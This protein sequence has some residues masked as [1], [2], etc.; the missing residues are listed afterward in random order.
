MEGST[1]VDEARPDLVFFVVHPWLSTDRWKPG[2]SHLIERADLVLVNRPEGEA[3]PPWARV[4]RRIERSRR[5]PVVVADAR[6]P[7]ADWAPEMADAIRR[8]SPMPAAG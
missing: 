5:G 2:A 6:R 3:R 1:I 7:M 4:L 8:A